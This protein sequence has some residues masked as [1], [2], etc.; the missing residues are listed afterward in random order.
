[1]SPRDRYCKVKLLLTLIIASLFEV[2]SERREQFVQQATKPHVVPA[3]RGLAVTWDTRAEKD[4]PR[5]LGQAVEEIA[6]HRVIVYL[7][8]SHSIDF[9]G[10][11]KESAYRFIR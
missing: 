3:S 11:P 1:M 9:K 8:A 10:P 7:C 2:L 4:R 5:V 6:Y